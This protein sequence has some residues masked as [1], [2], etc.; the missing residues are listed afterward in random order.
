MTHNFTNTLKLAKN[1]EK[2][3]NVV[4]SF[5]AKLVFQK[6]TKLKGDVAQLVVRWPVKP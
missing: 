1:W 6:L 4:L 5:Q 3:Q 2:G